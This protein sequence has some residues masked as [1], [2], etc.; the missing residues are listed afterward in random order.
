MWIS[1]YTFASSITTTSSASGVDIVLNDVGAPLP[2]TTLILDGAAVPGGAGWTAIG[3]SSYKYLR[4]ATVPGLHTLKS[5]NKYPFGIY[6]F[7]VGPAESYTVQGGTLFTKCT[8][9]PVPLS[10]IGFNANLDNKSVSLRWVTA[11]EINNDHFDMERS[12]DGLSFQKIGTVK[13]QGNSASNFY[14]SFNDLEPLKNSVNYYRLKQI[15]YDSKYTYSG[16]ISVFVNNLIDWAI[17]TPTIFQ[18]GD[19]VKVSFI[20]DNIDEVTVL[21]VDLQGRVILNKTTHIEKDNTE[22]ILNTDGLSQGI[23]SVQISS[24]KGI[25]VKKIVVQ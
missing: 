13:G 20:K 2:S 4:V 21:I 15:D 24:N 10:L 22:L 25:I 7:A 6:L 11:S 14:Y 9:I 16:I 17:I 5:T 8:P 3:T 23:Y 19:K 12:P 18:Q 1:E